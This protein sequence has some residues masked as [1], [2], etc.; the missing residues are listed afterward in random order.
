[1]IRIL[2]VLAAAVSVWAA[3]PTAAQANPIRPYVGIVAGHHG[4]DHDGP[5]GGTYGG[6]VGIDYD[7]GA[8]PFFVGAEANAAK[9]RGGLDAEY[10]I[11]A[12]AGTRAHLGGPWKLFARAG[13]ERVDFSR[14]RGHDGSLLV[15][16]GADY[17]P[18]RS[19]PGLAFRFNADTMRF[20][21]TRL[22]GGVVLRFNS[23]RG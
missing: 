12:T 1:M 4:Y 18:I 11:V 6:L 14:G 2:A 17:A 21:S 23:F 22:T 20:R 15:G 10:G 19:L 9:G 16:L 8:T 7:L 5:S 13:Y 3:A